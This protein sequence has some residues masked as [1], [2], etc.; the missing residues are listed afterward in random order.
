MRPYKKE[1]RQDYVGTYT[2]YLYADGHIETEPPNRPQS[3]EDVQRKRRVAMTKQK[4][5]AM[6][7][8][9]RARLGTSS[10]TPA[11]VVQQNATVTPGTV[12]Y[13]Q[14][15]AL[16]HKISQL[17]GTATSFMDQVGSLLY[18]VGLGGY[19][20]GD[21]AGVLPEFAVPAVKTDERSDEELALT[22]VREPKYPTKMR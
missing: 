9:E 11:S 22:V 2:A 6:L 15:N 17:S 18:T 13:A 1:T 12:F 16:L 20:I 5:V 10:S 3:K 4:A 7:A 8:A 21:K 14:Y 19:I